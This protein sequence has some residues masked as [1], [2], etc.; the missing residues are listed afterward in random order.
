MNR[1]RAGVHQAP[2]LARTRAAPPGAEL[3]RTPNSTGR[4]AGVHQAPALARTRAAPPGA[5]LARTPNST[6]R[7]AGR[8]TR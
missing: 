4:R 1:R 2:A 7:R 6:G 3:A 5:E 8:R